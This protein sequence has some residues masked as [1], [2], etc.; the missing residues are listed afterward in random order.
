MPREPMAATRTP[1][2]GQVPLA[3][4]GQ[5]KDEQAEGHHDAR[6]IVADSREC[7]KG[8]EAEESRQGPTVEAARNPASRE[9]SRE[10]GRI[11]LRPR[12]S[13]HWHS[14]DELAVT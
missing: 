13:I 4:D 8:R 3:G 1:A 6:H 10:D 14:P 11:L 2:A 7:T 12:F 5:C 9:V